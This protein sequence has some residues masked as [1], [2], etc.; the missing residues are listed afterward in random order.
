MK[1]LTNKKLSWTAVFATFLFLS[2][3][4]WRWSEAVELGVFGFPTWLNYFVSLQ[5]AFIVC[6]SI[7]AKFYWQE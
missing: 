7:F 6:L 3:D 2:L 5:I 4:Y 1:Q